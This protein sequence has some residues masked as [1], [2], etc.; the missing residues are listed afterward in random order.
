MFIEFII[1]PSGAVFFIVKL[2]QYIMTVHFKMTFKEIKL[3]GWERKLIEI[4][5]SHTVP[6]LSYPHMHYNI[7]T[8]SS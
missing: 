5:I 6:P 2:T 8:F 7:V 1:A 3:F 4:F